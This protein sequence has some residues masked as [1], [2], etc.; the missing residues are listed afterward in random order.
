VQ[1]GAEAVVDGGVE[2]FPI[3]QVRDHEFGALG[4][5]LPMPAVEV[6]D[7]HDLVPGLEEMSRDDRADVPGA[8]RDEELHRGRWKTG[9]MRA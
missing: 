5:S 2:D 6:V 8:S 7:D 1:D 3:E 4:H 9:R